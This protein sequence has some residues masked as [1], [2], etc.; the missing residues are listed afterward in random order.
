MIANL[1]KIPIA[2]AIIFVSYIIIDTSHN[3]RTVEILTYGVGSIGIIGGMFFC[4]SSIIKILPEHSKRINL[5]PDDGLN[6][7][8]QSRQLEPSTHTASQGNQKLQGGQK[9][10]VTR[11]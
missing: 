6:A 4:I 11:V 3:D 1:V 7:K 10:L 8:K 2:F 5:A 9:R